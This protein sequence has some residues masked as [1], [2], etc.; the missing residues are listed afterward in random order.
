MKK[1]WA[2]KDIPS[3]KVLCI[4]GSSIKAAIGNKHIQEILRYFVDDGDSISAIEWGLSHCNKTHKVELEMLYLSKEG[5]QTI[6][7]YIDAEP[8]DIFGSDS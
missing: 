6:T 7:L 2:I 8:E 1:T 4:E 5:E 3:N